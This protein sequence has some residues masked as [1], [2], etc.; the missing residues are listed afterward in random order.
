VC[1]FSYICKKSGDVRWAYVSNWFDGVVRWGLLTKKDIV[2]HM[3]KLKRA[4]SLGWA[5]ANL[6]LHL[7]YYENGKDLKFRT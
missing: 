4:N 5:F 3:L 6:D 2:K 1:A 7:I